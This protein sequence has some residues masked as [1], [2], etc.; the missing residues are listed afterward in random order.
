LAKKSGIKKTDTKKIKFNKKTNL[1][2][3][4]FLLII[5]IIIIICIVGLVALTLSPAAAEV[6]AQ[7]V[8]ESGDV[9][10]KHGSGSWAPAEDGM[11]LFASDSIKTGDNSTASIILFKSS[12]IRLNSNTEVTLQ[13]IIEEEE[14][15]V[16]ISQKEGRTWNTVRK[17]SG[18]DNYEVQTPTTVASV[19]GTSYDVNI[20]PDGNTTIGVV[21]GTVNIT[22][23]INGT[24]IGTVQVNENESVTVKPSDLSQSIIINPFVKDEW[25]LINE[26]KDILSFEDVKADL[27]SRIEEYIPELK[28]TYGI[29]DEELEA[30]LDG[31]LLGYYDLPPETPDWIRDII[32]FY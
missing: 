2:Q 3:N 28:A 20:L 4:K 15:S 12:I 11:D 29:T 14:T 13:E 18:I 5:P 1:T 31:Y 10:V 9:Q 30:L 27:Y 25:V 16:V 6:R 19:R 22:V 32:E 21:E 8:I 23:I 24:V 26:D 17:I 7:L